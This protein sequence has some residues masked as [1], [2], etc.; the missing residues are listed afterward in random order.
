M[1]LA[2]TSKGFSATVLH[3]MRIDPATR[4]SRDGFTLPARTGQVVSSVLGDAAEA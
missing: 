3:A 1:H 4:L 2:V